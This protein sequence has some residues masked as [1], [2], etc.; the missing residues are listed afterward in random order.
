MRQLGVLIKLIELTFCDCHQASGLEPGP[1]ASKT[2]NLSTTPPSPVY[3]TPWNGYHCIKINN[4][5][6]FII[7]NVFVAICKKKD[8]PDFLTNLGL[9]ENILLIPYHLTLGPSPWIKINFCQFYS[10]R[11]AIIMSSAMLKYQSKDHQFSTRILEH[12]ENDKSCLSK[13]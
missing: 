13:I 9:L 3:V 6:F 8:L 5:N 11:T 10:I 4:I 7:I 2:G 12:A 1:P